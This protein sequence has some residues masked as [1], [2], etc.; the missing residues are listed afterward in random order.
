MANR[1]LSKIFDITIVDKVSENKRNTK[2]QKKE[3]D[4]EHLRKKEQIDEFLTNLKN[5]LNEEEHS[6]KEFDFNKRP[7]EVNGQYYLT[8]SDA[9][10]NFFNEYLKSELKIQQFEILEK[11]LIYPIISEGKYWSIHVEKYRNNRYKPSD[12]KHWISVERDLSLLISDKKFYEM[13]ERTKDV[14]LKCY[15]NIIRQ[16]VIF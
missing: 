5:R 13:L 1:V 15:D 16:R 11:T 7:D 3:N 10:D 4:N 8:Y 2:K 14:F 9:T 12:V 6:K